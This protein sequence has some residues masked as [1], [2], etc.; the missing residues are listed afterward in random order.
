[1]NLRSFF[2]AE[3]EVKYGVLEKDHQLKNTGRLNMSNFY[4]YMHDICQQQSFI[5]VL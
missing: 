2:P 3:T 4:T 5:F 1:M